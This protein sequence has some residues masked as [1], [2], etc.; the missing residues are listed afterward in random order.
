LPTPIVPIESACEVVVD[1]VLDEPCWATAA[2]VT[3]FLRYRPTQ[4]GP[5]VG[6]TEVRFLQDERYFYVSA[7]VT[8]ADYPIRARVSPRED[9]NSDDQIGLYLDTFHDG[10]SGYVFYLNPLGIQQDAR[11]NGSTWSLSWDAPFKSKGRVDDDGHGYALEVAIPW[12][13]LKYG[14]G[15]GGDTWG[16]MVTRKIPSEGYKYGFPTLQNGHP[17]WWSQEA[18]LVGMDPPPAGSGLELIPNV[19]VGRSWTSD[20]GPPDL[21]RW[22]GVQWPE[23]VRPSADVRYGVTPDLGFAGTVNPDFSQ[24]EAD[25]SDVRLNARFAFQ[26]PERRPFFL[27][28]VDAYTDPRTTLYTRSIADPLYGA[29]VTGR[30]DRLSVG[31]VHAMDRSPLGSFHEDGAPGFAVEEGDGTWASNTYGRFRLDAFESGQVGLVL[32]DKRLLAGPDGAPVEGQPTYDGFGLDAT[33]PLG[34]RWLAA[35]TGQQSAV[36]T[37]TEGVY[38]GSASARLERT[39]GVG[40]GVLAWLWTTSPGYRQELGFQNY[41]GFV[42]GTGSVD[43]SFTDVGP[44]D[45]LRPAVNATSTR[46]HDD[47]LTEDV[48]LSTEAVRGASWVWLAGGGGRRR[49][50]GTEVPTWSSTLSGGSQVGRTLEFDGE[51]VVG[52]GLD[53]G[54]LTRAADAVGTLNLALRPATAIRVDLTASEGWHT[55]DDAD[56][57]PLTTERASFQRSRFTWQ[58]TR[59]LGTR[60]ILQH[61]RVVFLEEQRDGLLVSGLATLLRSPG[62][63]LWVGWNERLD[64]TGGGTT[65]RT[66]FAKASV[67]VRP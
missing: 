45:L 39:S 59:A 17:A 26:F 25:T 4:G 35:V 21:G 8:G 43:H 34:G 46:E 62:T 13:S 56:G 16:L 20:E 29:K 15:E 52:E 33:V 57:S 38:G 18:D 7:R 67:L 14:A 37:T 24:V 49:F 51:V 65:E 42:Q 11:V 48:T 28:G 2:P 53:Y 10:R 32:A 50:Q 40:T 58:F 63:A 36:S 9:I 66:V 12:R 22:G 1:G 60:W 31:L 47:E 6:V 41:S 54:T 27:D 64:L 30:Q 61:D 55:P 5:P 19:T 23:V 3:D 44:L